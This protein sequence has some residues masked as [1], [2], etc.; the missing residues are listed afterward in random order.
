MMG[1]YAELLTDEKWL[2]KRKRII[3]G[4]N[5]TCQNCSNRSYVK[6]KKAPFQ[7]RSIEGGEKTVIKVS[8]GC[9]Y[10]FT[11]ER[12]M[13]DYLKLKES[14]SDV[15][16][17]LYEEREGR[18]S[19]LGVCSLSL[20]ITEEEISKA[21]KKRIDAKIENL[22]RRYEEFTEQTEKAVR[23]YLESYEIDKQ[24]LRSS[25][26]DEFYQNFSDNSNKIKWLD[27][28]NLHVHHHYYKMN[29]LPWEYPDEALTTLCW[30]CHETLHQNIKVPVLD[31]FN[32]VIGN[33]T[34]CARCSGAGYFPEYHYILSGICFRCG[35]AKYEELI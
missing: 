14:P 30:E 21:H 2:V 3:E 18:G 34:P 1:R 26:V 29:K 9:V 23:F 17:V 24:E 32:Q 13:T 5:W 19:L 25:I 7:A 4:N 15:L 10:E 8:E 11:M 31:E 28:R 12:P 16:N 27:V 22:K 6:F 33:F 35:G 20:K